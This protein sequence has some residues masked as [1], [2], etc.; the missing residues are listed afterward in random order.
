VEVIEMRPSKHSLVGAG[1]GAVIAATVVVTVYEGGVLVA[2]ERGETAVAA[3]ERAILSGGAA[4]SLV[5]AAGGDD[6]LADDP[7]A[8][9]PP[10]GATAEELLARDEAQRQ[11]LVAL[12]DRVRTMERDLAAARQQ[13]RK[14]QGGDGPWFDPA[15]DEL[16]R[17]ADE[18]R[19]RFDMPPMDRPSERGLGAASELGL[20]EQERAALVDAFDALQRDFADWVRA[21][22]VEATGDVGGAEQLSAE[23]MAREIADK[24]M[25]GEEDRLRRQLAR[26]RAGLAGPPPDLA[27][28]SPLERYLRL[29][30]DLG[31]EAER[32]AAALLGAD[33]ARALRAR[34]E[35]WG[36]RMEMAG[37]AGEE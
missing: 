25:P 6:A 35:G 13:A 10:P 8:G 37:C 5:A 34:N 22:Y 3:G 31:D 27:K 4:P 30:A 29:L 23:A 16:S 12:R 2:G 21:L 11:Q 17:F 36:S 7:V 15:P 28:T 26:E 18:C 1:V 33:R 14:E 32:R 19:V 9:P 20:S 24:S